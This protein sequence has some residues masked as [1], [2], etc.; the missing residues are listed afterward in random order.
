MKRSHVQTCTGFRR[1]TWAYTNASL[2]RPTVLKPTFCIEP[3]EMNILFAKET[4]L[5]LNSK[6]QRLDRLKFYLRP[7]SSATRLFYKTR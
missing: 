6:A 3:Q 1:I 5:T 7:D 2:D 4:Y